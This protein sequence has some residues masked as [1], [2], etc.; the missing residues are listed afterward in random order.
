M[1]D[2]D[3]TFE[4]FFARLTG[5]RDAHRWQ[6]DLAAPEGC[7]NRLIRIPT[8][9]GKTLGVL[10]AWC[11]HRLERRDGD[12]PRRLA[13]CLP[14]RVL[15]EQTEHEVR[16]ALA[17]IGMLWDGQ[18]NHD[19]TVGVHPI[20]GGANA[21]RWHLFPECAAVLV[22]T[23][24]M[25]LSRALNRGYACPRARWPMEFGLLNQDTLW[26]MDEVQL[27]DVGLHVRA[28]AGLPRCRPWRGQIS[29]TLRNLV[30]ECDVAA[31]M[32][33]QES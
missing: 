22:G 8:G 33:G 21:G 1:A 28:T 15:V 16:S 24:D 12:W 3:T 7:G 9:F 13:W 19:G 6:S 30:D 14:M 26:V 23:Q 29:Q 20:M 5:G 17:R 25:L 10:A 27:M 31:G 32:A 2:P 18:G 11:W 4:Q